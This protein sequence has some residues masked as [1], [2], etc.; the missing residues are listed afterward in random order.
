MEVALARAAVAVLV[1]QRMEHR[2][3][4][5]LEEAMA[6]TVLACGDCEN[7]LVALAGGYAPL[8][9]SHGLVL[10]APRMRSPGAIWRKASSA[11]C[12][13]RRPRPPTSSR[14]ARARRASS[15]CGAGGSCRGGCEAA[16]RRRLP[17]SG[18]PS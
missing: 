13:S 17:G 2:L 11:E 15:D 8:N 16:C 12:A 9:A 18:E 14:S 4:R 6:S 3:V 1:G 10:L 5:R 7:S